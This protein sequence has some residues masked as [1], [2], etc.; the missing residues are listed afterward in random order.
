MKSSGGMLTILMLLALS[1][2]GGGGSSSPLPVV[3]G[4]GG[5]GGG[6]GSGGWVPGTFQPASDFAAQ[7]IA[8][9]SG[10]DPQTGQPHPDRAGTVVDQN[11]W[12][13]SWSND[14][15]LWY[16]E[17]VDRDPALYDTPSYFDLLKTTALTPSGRPKDNFHFLL[18]TE[19]WQALSQ[20]GVSA[21]YGAQ[22]ALLSRRAPRDVR[23]AYTEPGSPAAGSPADLQRGARILFVDGVDVVNDVS[24]AGV[25]AINAALFPSA[26]GATHVFTV[27]DPAASTMR[28]VT[29]TS[30][31]VTSTP[32]Q[33]VTVIETESGSVGYMLFNEHI[34]TAETALI[35]AVNHFNAIGIDD[36]VVDVRYNGGGFLGIASELSYMIAGAGR[37]DGRTFE[38]LRFN[39]K[40]PLRDPV[41][42]RLLQPIPFA[43]RTV[44]FSEPSGVPLPQL[45]LSR[46]FLLTGRET[47][48]ASESII[49]ALRGIDFPVILIGDTTCGKPYGFYPTDNCGTTFFS[50]QFKGEN[51]QG[52]GEYADG[53]SP[54]NS[55]EL[56]GVPVSG[57]A[58]IDDFERRL[59]DAAE[60]RLAAALGY[61]ETGSCPAPA[62]VAAQPGPA[63]VSKLTKSSTTDR[64]LAKPIWRQ[65]RIVGS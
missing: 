17:I 3:G 6:G 2:C 60:A 38:R 9:R 19:E 43:D 21:G 22:W 57:C 56:I 28:E 58:V 27:Q 50:V 36:L 61:R 40:H 62:A 35:E 41:T 30:M 53:F 64:Q 14:L 52:F 31:Q 42:G 49:N 15:Y 59:G 20:S 1:G 51:D 16:D 23:V 48:S 44:G 54:T 13:R 24:D 45:A 18:P 34:A 47:C 12:L 46:V 10:L 65:I 29:L 8:P 37:T 33:N 39:D 63:G 11:N 7:C 32:V 5:G 4:G 25:S 55:P 26:A